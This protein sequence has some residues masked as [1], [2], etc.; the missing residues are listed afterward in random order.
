ME[1]SIK[2]GKRSSWNPLWT[3][4]P[5]GLTTGSHQSVLQEQFAWGG[6]GRGLPAMGLRVN[7]FRRS[8]RVRA[9]IGYR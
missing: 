6:T 5:L 7:K 3:G 2:A 8:E 4:S 9:K 1:K